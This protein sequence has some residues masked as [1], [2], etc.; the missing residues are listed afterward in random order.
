MPCP[1]IAGWRAA[2]SS[3][4]R[5]WCQACDAWSS[6]RRGD[7][8]AEVAAAHRASQEVEAGA[9]TCKGWAGQLLLLLRGGGRA[10]HEGGRL[11]G[12]R[13]LLLLGRILIVL[14]LLLL[15]LLLVLIVLLLLSRRWL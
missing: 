5:S 14:L 15:L 3:C 12:R 7:V 1:T 6:G 9:G 4:W 2:A 11:D 10:R 8:V 13:L